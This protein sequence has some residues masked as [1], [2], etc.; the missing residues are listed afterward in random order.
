[1]AF[2]EPEI[3]A[4][5]AHNHNILRS[6]SYAACAAHTQLLSMSPTSAEDLACKAASW[7]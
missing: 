2:D 6:C 3:A 4:A 7:V 1:M 5:M